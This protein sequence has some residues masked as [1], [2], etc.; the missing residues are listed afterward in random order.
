MNNS[1]NLSCTLDIQSIF[2]I[3]SVYNPN[4]RKREINGI[5]EDDF[6]SPQYGTAH[7]NFANLWSTKFI[8]PILRAAVPHYEQAM[9]Q[10]YLNTQ[11]K[12]GNY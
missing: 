9:D 12:T 10:P 6:T 11:I 7:D 2:R 4:T 3:W 1:K 8:S 5:S